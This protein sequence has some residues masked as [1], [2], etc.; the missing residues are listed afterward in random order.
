VG[1]DVS[2]LP[3]LNLPKAGRLASS[4]FQRSLE[5]RTVLCGNCETNRTL[6]VSSSGVL[7]CST[8]GSK[9]WMYLPVTASLK[10]SVVVKGELVADEDLTIEGRAEGRVDLNGHTLWIASGG[11]VRAE[12]YAK[13]VMVAGT[14][15]GNIYATG[16][17]QIK[18]SG[19]VEGN[20]RC[21]RI[22][23]VDGAAFR[24][25]INTEARAYSARAFG[26]QKAASAKGP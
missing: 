21:S 22:S 9:N 15:V 11:T 25:R 6:A 14:V 13:N 17:V 7:I 4:G 3:N 8:C 16:A 10:A 2:L 23:I 24:G 12:I 5:S 19:S 26:S 1:N 18:R 20:I